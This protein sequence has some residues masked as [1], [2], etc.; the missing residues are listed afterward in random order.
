[1]VI[2]RILSIFLGFMLLNCGGSGAGT[3]SSDGSSDGSSDTGSSSSANVL[4]TAYPS[5]LVV[6]SLT[7]STGASA[8]VSAKFAAVEDQASTATVE[9]AMEKKERI[10][11]LLNATDEASFQ[12]AV[13]EIK[14][15]V[16]IMATFGGPK[17]YG[18]SLNYTNHPDASG[19]QSADGTLP[20]GD[21]G[22]WSVTEESTGEACVAA[23]LNNLIGQFEA[24]VN[25]GTESVAVALGAANLEGSIS[26]LP[27]EGESID[28]TEVTATVLEENEV[29]IDVA[30]LTVSRNAEDSAAGYPVFVT[31]VSGN[32]TSSATNV[33]AD[34]D[35]N[36]PTQETAV[37]G[38]QSAFV[39]ELTHIPMG[40]S[41][42]ESLNNE[43]YCGRMLQSVSTSADVVQV[44][45]NC[46]GA[47][48][49][50]LCTRVDYCKTAATE[51]TYHLRTAGF[52]GL[53]ASCGDVDPAD[54]AVNGNA[55][56]WS[57]NFFYTVCNVNPLDGTGDCT[58]A[59]QAGAMDNNTRVLNVTVAAGGDT[60][61]GYFG[62]GPDVAAS[63]GVGSIDGMICNWAGPGNS[64]A[65]S[66]K[67]QRQCFSRDASGIF[68]SD[69]AN[70]A[71]LYAP[72]NS[73]DKSAS[74]AFAYS[75]L[76]DA[77]VGVGASVDV[78]NELID[79]GDVVFEMPELP[80]VPE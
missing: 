38:G 76:D 60:G 33:P 11:T 9:S 51:I 71:I 53:E 13:G 65:L 5:D 80:D 32:I 31:N 14:D 19:G 27:A 78:A 43:T 25:I 54:K 26:D 44:P 72:T 18:P 41:D 68:V 46:E 57:N 79:L 37:T 49:M 52:C 50:T 61:C 28:L 58:Q 21:L 74:D 4:A 47:E 8:S 29:P 48:G 35:G 1:M 3:T 6:A 36:G 59:W 63:T 16:N 55:E 24:L 75:L 7:A 64:H 67:A 66:D 45:V 73:C 20:S 69:D 23:K 10:D 22:I 30:S 34:P 62:Y 15:K 17:C 77:A 70:L 42:G 40:E 2:I 39:T 56:G 12:E